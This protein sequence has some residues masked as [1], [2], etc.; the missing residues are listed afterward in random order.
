MERSTQIL[1]PKDPGTWHRLLSVHLT[2]F[3]PIN[4][5]Y[6]AKYS[7]QKNEVTF[8]LYTKTMRKRN[9]QV[10]LLFR[11]IYSDLIDPSSIII[12]IIK[13]NT[14]HKISTKKMLNFIIFLEPYE[15]KSLEESTDI[16]SQIA[17]NNTTSYIHLSDISARNLAD[18]VYK[19]FELL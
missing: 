16:Y 4:P 9:S 12:F 15:E 19:G 3:G 13:V 7:L 14:V 8:H 18:K 11:Y 5:L 17:H 6:Y 1:I 2:Y 10:K